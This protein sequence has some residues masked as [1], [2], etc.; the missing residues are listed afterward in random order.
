[1]SWCLKNEPTK[2]CKNVSFYEIK[3]GNVDIHF[4]VPRIRLSWDD[5]T[6]GQKWQNSKLERPL[7]ILNLTGNFFFNI[8]KHPTTIVFIL[9]LPEIN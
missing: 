4:Y 6:A 3:R 9:N 8:T 5:V 2:N 7:N 1:M